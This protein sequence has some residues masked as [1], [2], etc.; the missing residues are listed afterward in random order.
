MFQWIRNKVRLAV[1]G[2]VYDGFLEAGLLEDE[3][4]PGEEGQAIQ[5]AIADKVEAGAEGG[6]KKKR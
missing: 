2:G 3:A 5:A 6:S 1:V 4:K